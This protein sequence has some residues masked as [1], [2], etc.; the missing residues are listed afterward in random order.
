MHLVYLYIRPG[1]DYLLPQANT[2]AAVIII[3]S[4]KKTRYILLPP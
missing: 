3:A 1:M 4:S 2:A